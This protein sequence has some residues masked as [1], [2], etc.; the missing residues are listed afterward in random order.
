MTQREAALGNQ[1]PVGLFAGVSRL[2]WQRV[3]YLNKLTD[4]PHALD[5][6]CGEVSNREGFAT[7]SIMRSMLKGV[8]V[9]IVRSMDRPNWRRGVSVEEG[10]T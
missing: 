4:A 7:N 5:G 3:K 6:V 10:S 1:D 9:R 8:I 2:G